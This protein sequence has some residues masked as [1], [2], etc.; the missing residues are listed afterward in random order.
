[1]SGPEGG[2]VVKRAVVDDQLGSRTA[3]TW[4]GAA[5]QGARVT[6]TNSGAYSSGG[7]TASCV[8]VGHIVSSPTGTSLQVRV[9]SAAPPAGTV[10]SAGPGRLLICPPPRTTCVGTPLF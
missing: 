1:M 5:L 7:I 10:M 4:R 3:L 6:G 9:N 8:A 2:F